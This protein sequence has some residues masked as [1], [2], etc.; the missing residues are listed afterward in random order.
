MVQLTAAGWLE[1]ELTDR[2]KTTVEPGLPEPELRLSATVCAKPQQDAA[3]AMKNWNTHLE[4][5]NRPDT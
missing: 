3:R 5:E 2:F 4:I 1:V